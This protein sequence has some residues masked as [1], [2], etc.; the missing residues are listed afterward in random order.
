MLSGLPS[1]RGSMN[2]SRV[3]RYF[4]LSLASLRASVTRSSMPRH[5]EVARKILSRGLP[6]SV[7]AELLVA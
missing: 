1:Y 3:C 5:L 6:M 7:L 2:F 4:T